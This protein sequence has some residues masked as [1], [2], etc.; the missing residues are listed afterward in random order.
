MLQTLLTY[1]LARPKDAPLQ[2]GMLRTG[3]GGEVPVN[4]AD[5]QNLAVGLI[6]AG[7]AA[8]PVHGLISRG[9]MT[10]RIFS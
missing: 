8:T 6:V 5:G 10:W 9:G 7:G 1:I 4:V 3:T 2:T